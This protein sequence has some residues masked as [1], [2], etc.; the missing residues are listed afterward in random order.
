VLGLFTGARLEELGQLRVEDIAERTYADANGRE[1][2]AWF[3]HIREDENDGLKLK[4]V[5]S[6]RRVPVHPELLRL[7]FVDLVRSAKKAN[8]LWLFPLL[9]ANKYGRRTAKWGEHWSEYRRKICDV[10]DRRM[11]FHSF[12]HTFKDYARSARIEEGI[13]RQLMGHTGRDIAD[14][15]GSG[16]DDHSLV[17]AIAAY[18]VPGLTI[19]PPKIAD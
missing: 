11:V 4:N 10:T 2:R 7:G 9:R 1:R 14:H 6:E 3:I 5:A 13:Q 12:R 16:Y 18:K 17:E 15:Y 8:Q 19:W